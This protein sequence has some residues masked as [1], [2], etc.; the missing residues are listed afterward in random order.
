MSIRPLT[1]SMISTKKSI[2]VPRSMVDSSVCA[3]EAHCELANS[4]WGLGEIRETSHQT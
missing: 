4:D 2:C 3:L 1:Y